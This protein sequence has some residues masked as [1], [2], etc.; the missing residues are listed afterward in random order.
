MFTMYYSCVQTTDAICDIGCNI[1]CIP[2]LQPRVSRRLQLQPR[3]QLQ[4]RQQ[5]GCTQ[6]LYCAALLA[7]TLQELMFIGAFTYM[8]Y[9]NELCLLLL[10][11]DYTTLHVPTIC[12]IYCV[13]TTD[14]IRD[15]CLYSY[16]CTQ[17]FNCATLRLQQTRPQPTPFDVP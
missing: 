6:Q 13:P 2:P 10:C 17:A 7:V 4:T 16:S 15:S 3:L 11:I 12:T 9:S 8:A 1:M 5:H 14:T